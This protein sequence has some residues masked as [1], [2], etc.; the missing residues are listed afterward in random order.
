VRFR[1][2]ASD[3]VQTGFADSATATLENRPPT[4]RILAPA[5][6]TQLTLGQS[7]N[8]EAAAKDPQDG[9][10]AGSA[11][12]WSTAQGVLGTGDR[13]SVASL[14]LGT[15]LVTLTAT[16][17]PGLSATRTVTVVVAA[18]P[19]TPGPTMTVG[20]VRIGWQVAAGETQLQTAVLHV[21]NRGSGALA[22]TATS[23]SPWLTVS[24][25]SGI[26]P[27]TLT[28]TANPT[29]FV[30]GSSVDT[31]VTLRFAGPPP[32]E[33]LVPVRVGVGNTFVVGNE[34]RLVR[35]HADGFE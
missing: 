16:N 1:V 23:E 26:A 8:F 29:G 32:Q 30:A 12:T 13:I 27:A 20:P 14:P 15:H 33:I 2:L 4:P 11:L 21:G 6:T 9:N 17:S 34:I 3:G 24:A 28:L 35:I 22:F 31:A 18:D 5:V 7:V 10:L 25:P 19:G